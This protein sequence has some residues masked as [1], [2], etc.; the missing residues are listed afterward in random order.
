MLSSP[1]ARIL[2][3]LTPFAGLAAAAS[4]KDEVAEPVPTRS[5]PDPVY[6]ED[7][8]LPMLDVTC[9]T[10]GCHG[11]PGAGRLIFE[12]PDFMGSRSDGINDKN[13]ATVLQFVKFGAPM[14]SRLVLKPLKRRDG[15]LPHSGKTYDFRKRSEQYKILDEW[16]RG[17]EL[18][19]VAPLADAGDDVGAK[20]GQVVALDGSRSRDRRGRDIAWSWS[21][22]SKP[23]ESAPLFK[24]SDQATPTFKA[25]RVG[26]YTFTLE[27]TNG[28][29]T[30]TPS[31]VT[32]AVDDLPFV[33]L[34]A[35]SAPERE[36]FFAEADPAAS[37]GR[38]LVVGQR[39]DGADAIARF[40]ITIPEAGP[41]RIHARV[42]VREMDTT[43][44]RFQFDDHPE[45]F[46]DASPTG[47]Y[48]FLPV[49]RG[50]V[51]T[52]LPAAGGDVLT[53]AACVEGGRLAMFG[54]SGRPAFLAWGDGTGKGSVT[55]EV[56]FGSPGPGALHA[57]SL[58]VAFD[59]KDDR[60]Y[61][62]AGYEL[63]RS[64][65]VIGRV[66]AGEVDFHAERRLPIRPELEL[67]LQVEFRED[68]AFLMLGDGEFLEGK[69]DGPVGHG[70]VGLLASGPA[71]VDDLS[72]SV[73]GID[74]RSFSFDEDAWPEGWLS[75][76]DH[77]LT[78]RAS[79]DAA[80]KIDELLLT[81]ADFDGNVADAERRSVRA[82]YLDLL[83]RTPSAVELTTAAGMGRES[84]VRRL[85]G[86]L[87][88]WESWYENEL[89]YYLL[90]DN[91]RP[92]TPELE[93]LPARLANGQTN[94]RDAI[95][96]IV[97]S[98]Y[99]NARNPGN[100]TF[101][102][103]VLEQLLGIVVQDEV[104]ILEAGKKMYD[105]YKIA[106]FGAKG[107]SQSDLVSI[108]LAQSGFVPFLMRR[109]YERVFG[110]APGKADLEG[111]AT[112]VRDDARA[113]EAVVLEWFTSEEY[114]AVLAALRPK[115]DLM[116][117]RS[118]YVDLLE[119][120]P[121]F[122]EFRNFRNAL[123]SLAD[124]TPLR[125]V[126]AKVVID[127]GK[128]GVPGKAG[129]DARTFIEEQFRRFLGRGP[130]ADELTAFT[131]ALAD[132]AC[133]PGTLV[134]AIVSSAE[135]QHY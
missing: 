105:G 65:A 36:G 3:L 29:S 6:F 55:A 32:V 62:F 70:R 111:W 1:F 24:G 102:S 80:P 131:E 124:S 109:H 21:L 129:L 76:G 130:R 20:V 15:G 106:L 9:G 22:T 5:S 121:T 60:N 101:V 41:F 119:R 126:L 47:G 51:S 38:A 122:D 52:A 123:Q 34:P 16:I 115:S 104:R 67:S 11:G 44:L 25:D 117:I 107:E 30:S 88:F 23:E 84:L 49:A 63:G 125:S 95:Q 87:E 13:L 73:E 69:L 135:Y 75:R 74:A 46:L 66:K 48:R 56:A 64:R 77:V 114:E 97:I 127:S 61:R 54:S 58:V 94:V 57:T 92:K 33:L 18:R 108:V 120:P 26:A 86:S 79:G 2:L 91:F 89:Y 31:T 59:W 133:T 78:V 118:F 98:Q 90:L 17:V 81:R 8:V 134:H 14:E 71:T 96:Q 103:V 42:D 132:P 100:D 7:V 112:M 4:G 39:S 83:G 128:V 72:F 82:L 68:R 40:P 35:E 50:E 113:Y 19:E 99:F 12:R 45:M 10:S 43:P 85:V 53:G 27:V 116:W 37:G 110:R 93:A 28:E